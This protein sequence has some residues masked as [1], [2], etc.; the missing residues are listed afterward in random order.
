MWIGA[1]PGYKVVAIARP[2]TSGGRGV[3]YAPTEVRQQRIRQR[4]HVNRLRKARL[5][6]RYINKVILPRTGDAKTYFAIYPRLPAKVAHEHPPFSMQVQIA[7]LKSSGQVVL[8]LTYQGRDKDSPIY[9]LDLYAR[10]GQPVAADWDAIETWQREA[11]AAIK[12]C[13][14]LAITPKSRK[15]FRQEEE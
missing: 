14:E 10:S 5:G 13:F 4:R 6:Q 12:R 15:L 2:Q 8:T 9:I 1:V 3:E 11:H 7:P